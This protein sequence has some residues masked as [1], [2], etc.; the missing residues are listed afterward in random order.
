MKT[1]A[2]IYPLFNIAAKHFDGILQKNTMKSHKEPEDY[3]W[4]NNEYGAIQ[5]LRNAIF[6]KPPPRNANNIEHYTFVTLFS[7]KSDTPHPHLRYVTLE[8]PLLNRP[9]Y[10]HVAAK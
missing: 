10:R 1:W 8:W 3:A 4:L 2:F 9:P 6:L 7:R 5:V